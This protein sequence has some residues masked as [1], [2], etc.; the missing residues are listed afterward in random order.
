MQYPTKLSWGIK[1]SLLKY[2]ES[3]DD[4]EIIMTVPAARDGDAFLFA[5]DTDASEFDPASANGTLQF[6]GEVMLTGYHGAMKIQIRNPRLTLKDGQGVLTV[7]V[8]SVF[9]GDRLEPIAA[10]TVTETEPSLVCTTVLTRHGQALFG[11][12]YQPGQ[13][14]SPL[15]VS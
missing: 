1:E 12:Q 14:L 9:T 3:L 10:V 15:T 4:G 13:E 8:S 5:V 2:I 7:S 11:P 6:V